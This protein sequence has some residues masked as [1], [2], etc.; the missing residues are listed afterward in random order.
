MEDSLRE[1]LREGSERW[2]RAAGGGGEEDGEGEEVAMRLRQEVERL[3]LDEVLRLDPTPSAQATPFRVHE[4]GGGEGVVYSDVQVEQVMA[5]GSEW[6]GR[7][8]ELEGDLQA[9]SS[10]ID[11][12]L[13]HLQ[14]L[15]ERGSTARLQDVE[16]EEGEGQGLG[17]GSV[18][19][20]PPPPPQSG[21]E[22]RR[23]QRDGAGLVG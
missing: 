2:H 1:R 10:D 20:L 17:Q 9:Y 19:V 16:E 11:V 23:G 18:Q 4:A 15:E 3:R 8:L 7:M 22:E 13:T 14:H 12:L 5:D 21:G 6:G